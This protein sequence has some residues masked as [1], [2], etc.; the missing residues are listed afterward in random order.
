MSLRKSVPTVVLVLISGALSAAPPASPAAARSER[1]GRALRRTPVVD[2]FERARGAVVNI[3]A[4]KEIERVDPFSGAFGRL[5]RHREI[6]TAIGS[7]FVIHPEGYV[8]TN[9][10]VVAQAGVKVIFADKSEYDADRIAIDERHDLA[11]LKIRSD[12]TFPALALGRSDDLMVG[13]TVIAIGNPLGYEHTVTAGIVSAINRD[14]DAGDGTVYHRLIQTD[15]SINRGNSGGPLLNVLCELIGI[16]T[17]IRGDAQ[18]IGFAIP[19]DTL[20]EL[21]PEMLSVERTRRMQVGLKLSWHERTVVEEATGPA[22]AAGIKPGDEVVEFNGARIHQDIDYYFK[23]LHVPPADPIALKLN[24]AGQ[25]LSVRVQPALIPN[26]DGGKLLKAKFGI[27]ARSLTADEARDA[28]VRGGLV[29]TNVDRSSPAD[30]AGIR[31]GHII[32]QIGKFFP[33]GLDDVGKLLENVAPREA[34]LFRV[35]ENHPR[36]VRVM[37]G[38][39]LAR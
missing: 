28:G 15:A 10:H 14:L 35:V 39:L 4:T 22:A 34:V 23:L 5:G 19:V 26:P 18:N 29:V 7:G 12:H 16:N 1:D 38:E 9:A 36:F 8:V 17:A 27:T 20:R 6:A 2:V 11:V 32:V 37:E 30:E 3:Q 24:R 13:E 31:R 21:L 25:T 33:T